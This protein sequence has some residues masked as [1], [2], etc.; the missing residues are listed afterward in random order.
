MTSCSM[1]QKKSELFLCDK[2][3]SKQDYNSIRCLGT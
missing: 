2:A 3:M 1:V